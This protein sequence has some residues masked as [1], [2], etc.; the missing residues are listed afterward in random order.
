MNFPGNAFGRGN[1]FASQTAA[2]RSAMLQTVTTDDM[3]AIVGKLIELARAGN[4]VAINL[5]LDRIFGKA[6]AAIAVE[7][8]VRPAIQ[9][10]REKEERLRD[11]AIELGLEEAHDAETAD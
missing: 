11:L 9:S 1:P 2:L 7:M 6:P 5:L 8:A 10:G 3:K 4:L